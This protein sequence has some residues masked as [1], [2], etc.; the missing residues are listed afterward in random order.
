MFT[1]YSKPAC[2]ACDTAK[3]LLKQRGLQFSEVILDVGQPKVEG[4]TYIER[5]AL[6][7]KF[8]TARTVPQIIQGD[9][10]IGGLPEL[11][12]TMALNEKC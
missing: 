2:P 8:P 6:L 10:H 11:A 1:V 5:E 3:A 9:R 7:A 4:K 12:T